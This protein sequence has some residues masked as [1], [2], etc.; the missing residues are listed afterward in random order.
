M[1]SIILRIVGSVLML[2]GITAVAMA[3]MEHP[4]QHQMGTGK[5]AGPSVMANDTRQALGLNP[6]VQ[7]AMKQTMREHMEALHAIVAALAR[8]DFDK[9][10]A[11]AHDDLG[12]PKHHQAMQR[13]AGATFPPKY[14]ELAMAHHQ[15]AEDLAVVIPSQDIKQILP[16]LERTMKACV[17]CHEA[18]K[19]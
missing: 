4:H 1:E 5:E 6:A 14:H 10:A 7:E 17:T 9:A 16:Q 19:L 13:E 12:F 8:E 2:W 15:V 3:Q 18:Y 11:V